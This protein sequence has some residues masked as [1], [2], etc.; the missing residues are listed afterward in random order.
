MHLQLTVHHVMQLLYLFL[1]EE[2]MNDTLKSLQ[3][4]SKIPCTVHCRAV[5]AA[6]VFRVDRS[7]L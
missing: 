3:Q 1:Q 6:R 7:F 4:E 5:T 2:G